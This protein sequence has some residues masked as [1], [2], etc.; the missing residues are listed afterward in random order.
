MTAEAIKALCRQ[1]ISE[2][3]TIVQCT[4]EI[5]IAE[6]SENGSVDLYMEIRLDGLE[7]VQKLALALTEALS[8]T[9]GDESDAGGEE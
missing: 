9:E 2:A 4:D 1:L 5:T 3:G 7:H 8:V 6:T